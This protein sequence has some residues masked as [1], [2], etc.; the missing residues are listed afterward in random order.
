MDDESRFAAPGGDQQLDAIARHA[1]SQNGLEIFAE[2]V[3]LVQFHPGLHGALVGPRQDARREFHVTALLLEHQA[4]T[5]R[6][7]RLGRGYCRPQRGIFLGSRGG[8]AGRRTGGHD[9]GIASQLAVKAVARSIAAGVCPIVEIP[10]REQAVLPTAKFGG[11][12]LADL[13]RGECNPPEPDFV[14]L[15]DESLPAEEIFLIGFQRRELEVVAFSG[16]SPVNVQKGPFRSHDRGKM[17]PP[18]KGDRIGNF[19][20]GSFQ[21]AVFG[22]VEIEPERARSIG[23]IKV[24]FVIA[25]GMP[26]ID[27]GR[28]RA[29]VVPADPTFY[30]E[31]PQSVEDARRQLEGGPAVR[32]KENRLR[33]LLNHLRLGSDARP[34]QGRL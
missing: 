3:D 11:G 7:Q 30:G 25:P 29:P 18:A 27:R 21:F 26:E 28:P 20:S 15:P 14:E 16:S 32:Q 22:V 31:F 23:L 34:H 19:N 13:L 4:P 9:F 6:S 5:R 12:G 24:Q 8:P 33:P 1:I 17:Q 2:L 10:K